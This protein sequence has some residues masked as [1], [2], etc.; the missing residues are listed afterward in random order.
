MEDFKNRED[1]KEYKAWIDMKYRCNVSTQIS[2][3]YYGG[4]G[5]TYSKKLSTYEGFIDYIGYAPSKKHA[6]IRIDKD[7]DYVPDNMRWCLESAKRRK[8]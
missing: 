5:I 4:R 6:L 2:Y 8:K 3:K 1:M 7:G